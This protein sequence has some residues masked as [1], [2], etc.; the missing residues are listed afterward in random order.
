MLRIFDGQAPGA[1]LTL[2]WQ[3][4]RS[5]R[6]NP[7]D[8]P[9]T[10]ERFEFCVSFGVGTAWLRPLPKTRCTQEFHMKKMLM[11]AVVSAFVGGF[12]TQAFAEKQPAMAKALVHLE[13]AHKELEVATADKGGHRVKAM[14]LVADAIAEVR[15]GIE[16][17]NKH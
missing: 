11:V 9:L 16:F 6:T 13:N 4:S 5:S 12:A 1:T 14:A 7:S 17:D 2:P 8:E 15:A 10:F 3:T